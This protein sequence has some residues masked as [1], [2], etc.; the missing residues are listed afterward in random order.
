MHAYAVHPGMIAA[1]L[2]RH[3]DRSDLDGIIERARRSARSA[4]RRAYKSVGAGAATTFYTATA[5]GLEER[6]G[7]YLADCA[8]SDDHAP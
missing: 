1:N 2:G 3:L 8:I 4:G 7:A 5:P 6:G